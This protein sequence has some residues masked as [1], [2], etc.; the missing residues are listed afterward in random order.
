MVSFLSYFLQ[1]TYNGDISFF[2]VLH[3]GLL[4]VSIVLFGLNNLKDHVEKKSRECLD[5]INQ[6]RDL[7][8]RDF[9]KSNINKQIQIALK[10]L[11]IMTEGFV[12]LLK[13]NL[14]C[15]LLVSIHQFI[16]IDLIPILLYLLTFLS[17]WIILLN[18]S[19]FRYLYLY[20]PDGDSEEI[21]K[22]LLNIDHRDYDILFKQESDAKKEKIHLLDILNPKK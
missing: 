17:F 21:Q 1:N 20:D 18:S 5:H 4:A 11:D 10:K 16:K 2:G 6:I 3:L 19:R 7:E 15:L 8:K 14:I 12:S 22:R 13:I 9:L